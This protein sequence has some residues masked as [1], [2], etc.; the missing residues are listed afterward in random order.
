MK[1]ALDTTTGVPLNEQLA[2]QLEQM[3]RSRHLRSGVKLPSIRKM[4]ADQQIS[5]FPSSRHTT[6]SRHAA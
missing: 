5:R 1:L 2:R 6:R 4:A 3:I